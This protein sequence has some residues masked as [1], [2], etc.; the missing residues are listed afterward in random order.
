MEFVAVGR[1]HQ[2]ESGMRVERDQGKTHGSDCL[3]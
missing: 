3:R 1:D 2:R